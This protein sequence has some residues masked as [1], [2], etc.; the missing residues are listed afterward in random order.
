MKKI[1]MTVLILTFVLT[2][3]ACGAKSSFGVESMSDGITATAVNAE[4][5]SSATGY[6][7]P[8]SDMT[9]TITGD[10]EE[11]IIE[12]RVYPLTDLLSAEEDVLSDQNATPEEILQAVNGED[13][14]VILKEEPL[15]FARIERQDQMSC[16]IRAGEY[17]VLCTV[18]EKGATGTVTIEA[19]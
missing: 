15:A 12:V 16:D 1:L 11:G 10:M 14:S 19:K 4:E 17:V 7:S 8:G 5:G 18:P 2:M 9:L 13:V 6:L 3:A